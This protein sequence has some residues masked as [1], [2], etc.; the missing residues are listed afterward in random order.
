MLHSLR[1]FAEDKGPV[2]ISPPLSLST[3]KLLSQYLVDDEYRLLLNDLDATPLVHPADPRTNTPALTA[4]CGHT[5]FYNSGGV[6]DFVAPE[7]LW[8]HGDRPFNVS[9]SFL[10]TNRY[11]FQFRKVPG[12]A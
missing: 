3:G 6:V 9:L 4:K 2:P 8:P 5:Q 12:V 10:T 1:N 7:Q 11:T